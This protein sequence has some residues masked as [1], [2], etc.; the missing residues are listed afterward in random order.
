MILYLFVE[1]KMD[2]KDICPA[3]IKQLKEY[4]EIERQVLIQYHVL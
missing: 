1:S 3:D 4:L 2:D